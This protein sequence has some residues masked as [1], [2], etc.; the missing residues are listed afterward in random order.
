MNKTTK[1]ILEYFLAT[2]FV[3]GTL[4]GCGFVVASFVMAINYFVPMPIDVISVIAFGLGASVF[5]FVTL[6]QMRHA[7]LDRAVDFMVKRI[8]KDDGK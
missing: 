2:V 7:I 4:F 8:I 3:C 5:G 1:E 6:I